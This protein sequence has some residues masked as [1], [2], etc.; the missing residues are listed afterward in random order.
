MKKK[1]KLSETL[2]KNKKESDKAEEL[3]TKSPLFRSSVEWLSK[4]EVSVGSPDHETLLLRTAKILA[5]TY[6]SSHPVDNDLPATAEWVSRFSH[7]LGRMY[8]LGGSGPL[9]ADF[10]VR[11][12][13]PQERD[14]GVEINLISIP[15]ANRFP[16]RDGVVL[17]KEATRGDLRN[18][19]SLLRSSVL[20]VKVI[21]KIFAV[22]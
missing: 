17:F 7:N 2:E 9:F 16:E 22:E 21:E 3:T 11:F 20:E 8:L 19:V 1:S 18:F 4:T 15:D 6:L 10:H 13:V 12:F 5:H 14:K